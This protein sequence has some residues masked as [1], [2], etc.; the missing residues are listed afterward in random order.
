MI[1]LRL[2]AIGLVLVSCAC[3]NKAM[4]PVS[5]ARQRL[6]AVPQQ[7]W[8]SLAHKKIFFG[9]QSV[10]LNILDGLRKILS[11]SPGIKLEIRETSEPR[12][13]EGPLFAHA[14]IGRNRDPLGKIDHFRQLMKSGLGQAVDIAFFK[15][16]YVDIDRSTDIQALIDHYDETLAA[17]KAEFPDLIIVPVTAPL[18][19]STPGI[20][21]RIKRL[22]GLGPATRAD[23]I[24]R[25]TFNEHIRKTYGAA[26]WDLADVEATGADGSKST[27]RTRGKTYFKLVSGYSIDGGHLNEAGSQVVAADLLIRLA[28]LEQR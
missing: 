21:A 13:F 6:Q 20:K 16:C 11:S 17:L 28:S 14:R 8:D 5:G 9:H 22:L 24:K 7:N 1:I 4:D 12:D 23:N 19:T 25:N 18:T 2:I 15:L 26:I 27:F 10:G 3:Q